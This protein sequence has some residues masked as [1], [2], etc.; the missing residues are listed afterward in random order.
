LARHELIYDKKGNIMND[1][2]MPISYPNWS[3]RRWASLWH[4]HEKYVNDKKRIADQ[5]KREG[6]IRTQNL[7][8]SLQ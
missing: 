5:D 1:E 2:V 6:D 7:K 8:Y 3:D 4:Q